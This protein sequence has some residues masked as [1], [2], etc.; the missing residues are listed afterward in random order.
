MIRIILSIV[1][2]LMSLLTF[3]QSKIAKGSEIK[4]TVNHFSNN[5]GIA[6][7][8]LFQKDH[9]LEK[10]LQH[11]ET[12]IIDGKATVI[13]K[14]IKNGEYAVIC[15]H[16]ANDNGIL[17]FNDMRMP[18]EDVGATNTYIQFGPPKFNKAK[19]IVED[20]NVNLEIKF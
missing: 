6:I 4:I 9:F 18:L 15:H 5:K 10:P 3:S 13:F 2:T 20:K 8:S 14:N 11:I 7:F 12:E 17:D 19:F 1:L 16:D